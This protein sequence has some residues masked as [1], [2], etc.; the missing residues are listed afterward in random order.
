MT[1][2]RLI[3]IVVP[4]YNEQGALPAFFARMDAALS[5]IA[6]YAF[7]I[8]CV[9]DASEDA[10]LASLCEMQKERQDFVV[11]DLSRHF[12][13]ESALSA[14]I[15]IAR[16][17]AVVLLDADLQD[18]PELIGEMIRLWSAG[19]E[20]VAA[21]R[22]DRSSDTALK[23]LSAAAFYKV[24]NRLSDT[25]LP[26]NVGDYRLMDRVVVD[27]LKTLPE[28]RRFMKGLFAWVGFRTVFIPYKRAQ[29]SAGKSRFSGWR[30]WN[31]ALEAIT[32][33]SLF[34]LRVWTYVGAATALFAFIYGGWI[35][36]RTIIF[37]RDLPG[38]ASLFA[39]VA[40][41]GGLQLVGIGIVGEYLG[42]TYL[43]SKRRPAYV[44]RKVLRRERG[45]GMRQDRSAE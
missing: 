12:G 39:A 16:G 22:T 1:E 3:S 28:N 24:H 10:T 31:L 35:V 11:V 43:E 25:A 40:F 2:A 27:A 29:R 4:C 36:V 15:D 42:R 19:N 41:L 5:T 44:I 32:S 33:F 17:D 6:G 45:D 23:R 14:G 9:N 18:P 26:E 7:E 38:Y 37:G 21:Q 20:V 13:K 8:V 30:L 34:P